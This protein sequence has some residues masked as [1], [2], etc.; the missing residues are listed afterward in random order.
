MASWQMGALAAQ[1]RYRPM[2]WGSDPWANRLGP[3]REM[4]EERKAEE[5]SQRAAQVFADQQL[6]NADETQAYRG[7]PRLD[8]GLR[9][10]PGSLAAA[11]LAEAVGRIGGEALVDPL[12]YVGG[13]VA[14]GLG[15]GLLGAGVM[16]SVLAPDEAQA[17]VRDP[18][19]WS[20]ISKIKLS[21]PLNEMEHRFTDVRKPVP[22][23]IDPQA[24]H[25][26]YGHFTPW[27][28]SGTGYTLT[29][30]DGTP[31]PI[32]VRAHGGVGFPAANP[33]MAAASDVAISRKLDNDAGRMARE[34]GKPQYI[35]PM[36]MSETGIDAS[37][38]VADPLT[39]MIQMAPIKRDDATEF[40]QIMQAWVEANRGK[41]SK[42]AF[43]DWTSIRSKDFRDSI[44]NLEGGMRRK[45]AMAKLAG[46]AEWQGKGFPEVGA[47]RHA[48]TEPGLIGLPRN[49]V[50][51]TISQYTPGQGLLKTTHPTYKAG[52]AGQQM[53]Q[54]ASLMPF[55]V[56]AP[57]IAKGLAAKNAENLAAGKKVAIQPAYHMQKPTEGV[58]TV[59]HFDDEWLEGVMKRLEKDQRR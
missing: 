56:F 22:K 47:I 45:S 33:G 24:L 28:L 43:P 36:T 58:P 53:G 11:P 31:L 15:R 59:Q 12:T 49:T 54:L 38:H 41:A 44:A 9:R 26:G 23:F 7:L 6:A 40:N 20:P 34:T 46:A 27:D 39:Q 52:V 30:V 3:T 48:M 8:P 29:H 13:G 10:A 19:L 35:I 57:T 37:H 32:P 25:G 42:E 2:P 14:T 51:M 18:K 1:D 17:G 50:G 5:A 55:D 16:G 4:L 21:K